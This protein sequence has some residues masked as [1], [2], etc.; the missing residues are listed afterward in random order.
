M[1][2]ASGIGAMLATQVLP[3]GDATVTQ[4]LLELEKALYSCLVG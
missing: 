4:C 2:R 1:D 3:P